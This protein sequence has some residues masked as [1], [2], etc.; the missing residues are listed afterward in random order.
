[1]RTDLI[2]LSPLVAVS[3]TQDYNQFYDVLKPH[4][5]STVGFYLFVCIKKSYRI[6]FFDPS[7]IQE[8]HFMF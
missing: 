2:K 7:E 1:M 8:T 5:Q 3:N 6:P 4:R